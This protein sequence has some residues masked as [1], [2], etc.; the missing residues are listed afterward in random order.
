VSP[1]SQDK[2][3]EPGTQVSYVFTVTNDSPMDQEVL[4]SVEATWL[5]EAPTTTGVLAAGESVGVPVLV[6]IPVIPDV[7]IGQDTFTLTAVGQEG[8]HASATGTTYANVTPS[9]EVSAPA[10]QSGEPLDVVSYAF[11]VTN[12]GNYTDT[13]SIALSGVW[14]ATLPGGNST[15]P[16]AAGDS[17]AITVLVTIPEDAMDGDSDVT[18]LT[19]TSALDPAVTASAE[20]TTTAVIPPP[21]FYTM[22]PLIRR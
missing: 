10:G 2:L 18:T 12:S 16:L 1:S 13:F 11:L 17:L 22:L 20:V 15:G 8:G 7:I 6:D 5:T 14:D 3:G 19:I 9:G 21:M 4:L